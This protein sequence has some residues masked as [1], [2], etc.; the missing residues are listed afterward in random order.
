MNSAASR[1]GLAPNHQRARG[2][3]RVSFRQ[4][5]GR[6]VLDGLRQEGCLKARFPRPERGAWTS[7]VMLNTSGGVAGGDSLATAIGVADG[8]SVTVT[9]QTAERFYRA[10]PTGGAAQLRNVLTVGARAAAEWL[11]QE[12]ILFD[13]CA[14]DRRLDVSLGSDAWFLGIE[15]LVFG[16]AAMGETVKQA[17][18]R[19]TVRVTRE[20]A[21]VLHD[22]VRLDGA[23][24]AL[25]GRAAVMR[26]TRGL[27]TILLASQ[28]A[29]TRLDT[30][31]EALAPCD[32]EWG[33][34]AW[35]GLLVAR[36]LATDGARLRKAMIAGIQVLRATRPMPRVWLC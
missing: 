22:A 26:G 17:T 34:S 4:R 16:R 35:N 12:T 10:L 31:R 18:V 21:L 19:D 23:V 28:D 13:R 3:L 33:A 30:L 25:L 8:A 14:L 6:T 9:G 36:I 5:E 27:A 20:S 1:F 32:A 11:P 7:M 24:E 15:A 2:E 29:E